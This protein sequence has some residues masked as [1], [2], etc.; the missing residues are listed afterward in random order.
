MNSQHFCGIAFPRSAHLIVSLAAVAMVAGCGTLND[1]MQADKVD[2]KSNAKRT[3]TLEVPPDLTS[4]QGDRRYAAP[5]AGG[6]TT[7]S[8]YQQ[9]LSTQQASGTVNAL[10]GVTGIRI[11]RDG[12]QRWLVVDG[13]TASQVWPT[14][15]EF[16][17]ENGFLLAIDSPETGIMETDWAENR[18]KIP[19]DFIR[20]TIGKVFDSLYSTSERDRFRTRV[21]K[22]GSGPLEI[23]ISHRGVQEELTGIGKDSSVWVPRPADPE[24]E[25]EFLSRLMQRMGMSR[26]AAQATLAAAS[27]NAA[28][29]AASGQA[30]GG[31]SLIRQ[32]N[33][34]DVLV[35]N[36]QF[37]RAWRAVGL[38]LDRVNF[39]VEDRDRAKGVYFVRYVD[40][41]DQAKQPGFFS[42]LFSR[43]AAEEAKRAKRYQ[44]AV[45]GS[46]NGSI[47]SVLNESGAPEKSDINRQIL[48]L[49]N[50]QLR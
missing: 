2:Y 30:A 45:Q 12:N 29:G 23:F 36:E 6:S 5:E 43:S 17:Q 41:R 35:V 27:K 28:A 32:V 44:V 42:R 9:R 50:E 26:E 31:Q 3:A 7:L 24:L 38:A 25:A 1:A 49:L 11:E 13:A 8:G 39:T 4:L 20:N 48:T 16:W 33:G 19:Q 34:N 14:L 46:G 18:A 22:A 10:P 47:V 21:E 15:R 40:T 37:D